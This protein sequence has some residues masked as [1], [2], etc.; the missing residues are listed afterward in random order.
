MRKVKKRNGFTPTPIYIVAAKLNKTPKIA[1]AGCQNAQPKCKLMGGFSLVELMMAFAI[2]VI[3]FAA[4]VPQFRAIRNS[5][6]GN[7]AKAE[8]IQ[9]GRVL[10]E[11][12]T[13]SLAAAKQITSVSS[14]SITFWDNNDVNQ[15]YMLSGG[16]VV[17]GAVGSEAQLAGPVSSFQISCYSI[18]PCVALTTD[19]NII[20]LVQIQTDFPNT[21]ALGTS[22]TFTVSVYLRTNANTGLVGHWK[23][24]E[25]S[26]TTAAD[27]S[28]KGN[29]GT[30]VNGP[31]LMPTGGLIGGTLYCD[32][33]ND[34]VNCG[35]AASLNITGA[36][37]LAVWVK[38]NDAGNSQYNYFVGKGD[39]SY[40]I[41]HQSS[42]QIEFFI[43]DNGAWYNT[44]YALNTSFNGFWHHLAGTYDRSQL[45]L[46]VDGV[47]RD[48]EAHIGSIKS[49]AY[50][51]YI[52]EN[53]QETGCY[54]NGNI[55][56]VRIYNRALSANEIAQ[57][58]NVL[59]F[60][61]CNEAFAA[62]D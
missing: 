13:R 47:L 30:L 51:V 35:N 24:D 33:I 59:R 54:Y 5:W 8:I 29:N 23:L 1:L 3:I 18:D 61:D 31:N 2:I 6:T 26:G 48:T 44:W 37:T 27:S 7:E 11:H 38:T 58:A 57:L 17:F 25:T 49:T 62:S 39:T 45:K 12:I 55:D 60:R 53:S 9:N 20:R 41:Q 19:C 42:N 32:G 34:Y 28:G 43:Y 16:Y 36:I 50:N 4:I 14:S 56:D 10:V 40:A 52:G 46:Y 21:D 22:K 15:C